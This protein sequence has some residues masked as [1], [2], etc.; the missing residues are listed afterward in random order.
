MFSWI[1]VKISMVIIAQKVDFTFTVPQTLRSPAVKMRNFNPSDF[2]AILASLAPKFQKIFAE[3]LVR[4]T[5]FYF[6]KH[7]ILK[8]FGG[9][10]VP[11]KQ[12]FFRQKCFK[13]SFNIHHL[14]IKI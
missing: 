5:G 6:S 8:F 1:F 10:F 4:L 12:T 2:S 9:F 3:E 7:F 13:I 11:F 14:A